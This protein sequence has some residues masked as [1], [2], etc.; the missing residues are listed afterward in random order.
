MKGSPAQHL[1]APGDLLLI[2]G[3]PVAQRLEGQEP[4]A[5]GIEGDGKC[6]L[7]LAIGNYQSGCGRVDRFPAYPG[8]A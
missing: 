1:I 5:S 6:V 4:A 2:F 7:F 8:I 3:F